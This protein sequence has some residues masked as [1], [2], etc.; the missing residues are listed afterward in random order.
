MIFTK[1]LAEC[2]KSGLTLSESLEMIKTSFKGK[3]KS[4]VTDIWEKVQIGS[5]LHQVL[6]RYPKYFSPLYVNLVKIGEMSGTLEQSFE[7]LALQLKKDHELKGKITSAMIYPIIVF[8]AVFGLGFAVSVFVLPKI[9]PLFKSLDVELPIST[10]IMLKIAGALSEHPIAI[11]AGIFVALVLFFWFS[12]RNFIKPFTHRLLL[13]LPV[14]KNIVRNINLQRFSLAF[15]T[16]LSSGVTADN[17]LQITANVM[18]NVIYRRAVEYM[19]REVKNGTPINVLMGK[20]PNLFPDIAVHM[21]ATGERT[22]TMENSFKYLADYY[23]SE[24]DETMKN[25]PVI[26]EPILLIIIGVIVATVAISI[27]GP[28]YK[29]TANL[30]K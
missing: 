17:G 23:E 13:K 9:I 27:L 21:I 22:G 8:V 28:I 16:L 5:Q 12:R 26:I 10:Q 3:M 25:L 11:F 14:I 6:E 1:H 15:S 30:R 7:R 4:V 24:V 19:A 29:I 18:N 20:F 2:V